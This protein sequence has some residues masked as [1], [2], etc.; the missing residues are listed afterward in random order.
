MSLQKIQNSAPPPRDGSPRPHR[1]RTGIGE[2]Y[3]VRD[4]CLDW[5]LTGVDVVQWKSGRDGLCRTRW[6][7]VPFRPRDPVNME[8]LNGVGCWLPLIDYLLDRGGREY[9]DPTDVTSSRVSRGHSNSESIGVIIEGSIVWNITE[10][11]VYCKNM[12]LGTEFLTHISLGVIPRDLSVNG[13][14][15]NLSNK[16][17][18]SSPVKPTIEEWRI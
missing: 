7:S 2:P 17:R 12:R 15:W 1:P 9:W 8:D 11:K 10:G 4:V 16:D 13:N 18:F 5:R 14:V 3:M 6:V